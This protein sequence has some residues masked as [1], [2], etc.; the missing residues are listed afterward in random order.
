MLEK[1]TKQMLLLRLDKRLKCFLMKVIKGRLTNQSRDAVE[2]GV[3]RTFPLPRIH[4][5]GFQSE[6]VFLKR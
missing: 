2:F 3:E 5:A 6:N 1:K 4:F